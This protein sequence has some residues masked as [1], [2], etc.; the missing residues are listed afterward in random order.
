MMLGVYNERP[1]ECVAIRYWNNNHKTIL[2]DMW[3]FVYLC[4]KVISYPG[5]M[6][7]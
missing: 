6:Y 2:K 1:I 4:A 7:E 5:F 3:F